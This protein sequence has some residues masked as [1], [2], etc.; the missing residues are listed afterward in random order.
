LLPLADAGPWNRDGLFFDLVF[1]A[2]PLPT[3]VEIE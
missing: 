1:E 2:P 3:L